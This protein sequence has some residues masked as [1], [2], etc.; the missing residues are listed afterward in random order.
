MPQNSRLGTL[1][2]A[3]IALIV[4]VT[5][6]AACGYGDPDTDYPDKVRGGAIPDPNRPTVF[7]TGG[8]G[9][10]LF[11][12]DRP[13]EP[14]GGTGIGVN[15]YL[16]RASLDT[17]SF[18]P[19]ASADPFGGIIITDW[20]ATPGAPDER[21]KLTVYILSRELRA[22]GLRVS[23]FR[24]RRDG[25]GAWIDTPVDPATATALEDTILTRARQMRIAAAQ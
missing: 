11:G 23:V 18:M 17:I 4:S 14:R 8:I 13:E 15:F 9:A 22:D 24:Q 19:L 1:A 5:T 10:S 2:I 7:G 25:T 12:S 16:W 6:L 21:Y 3:V 20:Y